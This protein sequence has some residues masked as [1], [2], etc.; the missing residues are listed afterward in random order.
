M[1]RIIVFFLCVTFFSCHSNSQFKVSVGFVDAFEDETLLKARQGFFIALKDS[2]FVKDKNMQVIYRNAQNDLT[3][4]T[5]SVDYLISQNVDVIATNTTLSTITAVQRKSSNPICMMVSPS[6]QLAGLQQ[7]DGSDPPNLFGVY[8]TLEYIDTA[9]VLLK[10]LFPDAQKVGTII[11]Q[12]EPQSREALKRIEKIASSLNIEVVSKPCNNSAEAQLVTESLLNEGIDVF[13]ALPDNTIFAAFETIASAC[14][15]E[16]IPILSSE[17][18]L[19]KRGALAA[20][21]ADIYEWGY[22]AGAECASYL[23]TKTLPKPKKLQKRLKVYNP[24]KAKKYN[25]ALDSSFVEVQ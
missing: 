10:T 2:G 18:G 22:A 17:A 4:L 16:N 9:F 25:L 11:N 12:S 15:R 13:F 3:V 1:F 6:P 7:I 20:F 24:L 14:D 23:K 8:E 21:G 19:V 5:Q